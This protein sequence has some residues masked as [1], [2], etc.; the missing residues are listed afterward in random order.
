MNKAALLLIQAS[1]LAK[2]SGS[3]TNGQSPLV[4]PNY[5]L[6]LFS[7]LLPEEYVCRML[8]SPTEAGGVCVLCVQDARWPTLSL[9]EALG[10]QAGHFYT[11]P[12]A[13]HS[14]LGKNVCPWLGFCL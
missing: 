5:N 12:F 1:Y 14:Y 9:N 13:I 6:P 7:Q 8:P 2:Y 10:E 4:P 11:H 3:N